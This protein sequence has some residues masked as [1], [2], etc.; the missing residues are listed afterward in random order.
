MG[1]L[2]NFSMPT[3][4]CIPEKKLP[5]VWCVLYSHQNQ[6]AFQQLAGMFS[7]SSFLLS[8]GGAEVT[9]SQIKVMLCLI[10]RNI[11]NHLSLLKKCALILGQSNWRLHNID[12]K[13]N[14][15]HTC[16]YC[17]VNLRESCIM[18]SRKYFTHISKVYEGGNKSPFLKHEKER[19]HI[20]LRIKCWWPWQLLAQDWEGSLQRHGSGL[21]AGPFTESSTH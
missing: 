10:G 13:C 6:I 12:I 5:E 15:H 3:V 20:Y 9:C 21:P 2:H 14:K 19:R 11:P 8:T 1:W 16:I 4:K 18:S 7:F 17:K